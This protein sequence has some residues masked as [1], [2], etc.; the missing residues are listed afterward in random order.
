VAPSPVPYEILFMTAPPS[1]LVSLYDSVAQ[2]PL[3]LRVP[4]GQPISFYA[5]GITPHAAPHVGHARSFVVFDTLRRT[6]EALGW[7]VRLVR[8]ITDVDDKIIAAAAR[9]GTDWRTLAHGWADRNRAFFR[10]LGVADSEEPAV[11][12][13]IPAIMALIERLVTKGHAYVAANGD[14]YFAVA[15]FSGTDVAHQPAEA[16]LSAQQAGRVAHEHK[17]EAADFAL[18]K[19]AKPGEPAWESPWGQGRPGWHIECSAMIEALFGDTLTIHGGGVDLRFPHH[20]CEICQSEAAFDRPLANHWIHHGSVL[21]DGE[22]MSK[23]LGNVVSV[24]DALAEAERLRPGQGGAVLRWALLSTLWSKP[25]DWNDRL[26]PR[27]AATVAKLEARLQT[28]AVTTLSP[29]APWSGAAAFWAAL[30]DNFNVPQAMA[31]L[32]QALRAPASD[33]AAVDAFLVDALNAL[34]MGEDV[35]PSA[36]QPVEPEV[37]VI[38]AQIQTWVAEREAFRQVKDFAAADQVRRR[39]LEAGWQ[40]VDRADGAHVLPVR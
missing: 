26:L 1:L 37:L 18:W 20:Q 38:P 5:C 25:L 39:L 28:R 33:R 27:A 13:H 35:W 14:V 2:R 7:P 29:T 22:K 24:E 17:R 11:S 6:L 3:P 36:W 4:R 8:N 16:L 10:Q 15:T 21:R 9:Q 19:A 31:A 23:T 40:V 34:G 30:A 32:H 12:E